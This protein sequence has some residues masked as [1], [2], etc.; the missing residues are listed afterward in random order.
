MPGTKFKSW[1]V[2]SEA[3][4]CPKFRQR[5]YLCKCECGKE[6]IILSANL[7]SPINCFRC[8]DCTKKV[9]AIKSTKHG[10]YDTPIHNSWCAMKQRCLNSNDD[11]Y[12]HYGGRGIKVCERWLIFENFVKDMG[13][14][15]KGYQL[16]RINPDGNY[17]PSNC[18]WVTPQEN[19]NNRRNSKKYRGEYVYVRKNDLCNGCKKTV[20]GVETCS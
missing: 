2:I 1:E 4:V 8:W 14:P 15:P 10:L 19:N 17:E 13:L 20:E 3:S 16:D 6:Q 9:L 7:R 5:R 12:H 11:A 18:R